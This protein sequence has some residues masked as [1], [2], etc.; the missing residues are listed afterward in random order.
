MRILKADYRKERI[1]LDK[2]QGEE[3]AFMNLLKKKDAVLQGGLAENKN[4][5]DDFGK[6]PLDIDMELA[7][8]RMDCIKIYHDEMCQRG[9][10]ALDK[11]TWND[12]ELDMVY[13][14]LNHTKS[15]VGEQYLY[16][17]LHD[18]NVDKNKLTALKEQIEFYKNNATKR[19]TIEKGLKGF[20]KLESS[21]YLP[22]F[23]MNSQNWKIPYTAC[24][25]ILQLLLLAFV[26]A[27]VFV[28]YEFFLGIILIGAINLTVYTLAKM[29]YE[30]FLNAAGNLKQLLVFSRFIAESE[31]KTDLK[32][33]DEIVEICNDMKD[34]SKKLVRWQTRKNYSLSGDIMAELADFLYG[35]T[36][37]E[38]SMFNR[39]MKAV[40]GRQEQIMKLY[41]LVGEIDMGISVASFRE[42]V[43]CY[44]NPN[45]GDTAEFNVKSLVHPL[46]EN[47][48]P[49]DF[50]L[51]NRALISGAN[52][53]GK[54]TFM[55][56]L[57][58]NTILA[59]TIYTCTAGEFSMPKV[60][61]I[62]SM[63]LRDDVVTGNSYYIREAKRI[64]EM[65]N[66]DD[67]NK[68]SLIVIDEILKG[69]NTHERIAASFAILDYLAGTSH[70]VLVA[71]HDM[72]LVNGMKE[73]YESFY[74]ESRINESDIT[75]DYHINKGIG[76]KSNAI[77]LLSVLGYPQEIVDSAKRRFDKYDKY[78]AT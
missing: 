69:T 31:Y 64:K 53:S 55:K 19:R 5:E 62:S 23:L 28:K 73:R 70:Y 48:V 60:Y 11:T 42:S 8:D 77:A 50:I 32:I 68:K 36:L 30:E 13:L 14:R 40:N 61:V 45:I 47:A 67:K 9:F 34:V 43:C 27:S 52:A 22:S 63:A 29:R 76:G 10:S 33:S 1:L 18:V 71:T 39:V 59:Q 58:V 35:V 21:F 6:K 49:N 38:L 57:A 15:Y 78:A 17:R 65:L 41:E 72:E 3:S 51:K 25:Y 74:F 24:Y 46:I 44:C 37:L 56:A 16:H 54:S 2:R 12:L 75:F 7:Y 66:R 20:G 4:T 26:I